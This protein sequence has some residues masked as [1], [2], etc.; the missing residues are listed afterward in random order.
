MVF[1][2]LLFLSS[3]S[4]WSQYYSVG[5]DPGSVKWDQIITPHFRV[6]FPVNFKK[7]AQYTING[8]EYFYPH[9]GRTLNIHAP[10]TPLI[11]HN[12]TTIPSSV[13]PYAP[14]RIEFFTTP[15]Q[16]IYPQDWIDQ[17]IIHEFRHENQYT[18]VNQGFTRIISFFLGQ[19]AVPAVVAFFVPLW[20]MEGDAT[21]AETAFSHTGRGRVPSFE[22][23]LRAQFLQKG[24]Y[25]YDKGLNGSFRDFVPDKYEIGYQLVGLTRELYGEYIWGNVLK[26]VG[27]D[28]F[29]LTPFSS[30]LKKQTG[31]GKRDL[32]RSLTTQ[33]QKT[34]SETDKRITENEFHLISIQQGKTYTNYNLPVG[35]GK[36]RVIAEKSSIDDLTKIVLLG[37]DGKE[38]RLFTAGAGYM[39]ESLSVSDSIIYWS[40]MTRDPR[41]SL[42]DDR[43]IKTYNI[44]TGKISQITKCTRYFAPSVTRDGK[45][46]AAVDVSTENKYSLV[47]LNANDGSLIRKILNTRKPLLYSP[48]LV[49][50]W[51][52][53]CD[54]SLRG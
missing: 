4:L 27:H 13:T 31:L 40:E 3:Q 32:Y 18:A 22:M 30:S 16:D 37:K 38:K 20:F 48:K 29:S 35:F 19:Q 14:R 9:S 28:P 25:S 33:M 39:S 8:L 49:R 34:W 24:I 46:I 23:H 45:L 10:K 42:K 26:K 51:S 6:I 7:Q 12:Q 54:N 43:V 53:R 2:L 11:L 17:L 15:P 1:S 47:I 21:L 5:T 50:R 41:W 52:L 36:N 44:N